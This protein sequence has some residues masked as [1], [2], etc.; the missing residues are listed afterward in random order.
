[1]IRPKLPCTKDCRCQ[2]KRIPAPPPPQIS[3]RSPG[4]A[5]LVSGTE[6]LMPPPPPRSSSAMVEKGSLKRRRE[7]SATLL[8]S[9]G[10]PSEGK[11]SGEEDSGDESSGEKGEE[12]SRPPQPAGEPEDRPAKRARRTYSSSPATLRARRLPNLSTPLPSIEPSPSP[13]SAAKQPP[14]YAIPVTQQFRS[15]P[16]ANTAPST[17]LSTAE[18]ATAA[19]RTEFQAPFVRGSRWWSPT[20][21]LLERLKNGGRRRYG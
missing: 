14:R 19:G 15:V 7:E 10:G 8:S 9:R 21:D 16:A 5:V 18:R 11:D 13:S 4:P 12:K 1:M 20:D 17:T 2:N 3:S 6:V